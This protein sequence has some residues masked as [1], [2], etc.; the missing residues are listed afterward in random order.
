MLPWVLFRGASALFVFCL[1]QMMYNSVNQMMVRCVCVMSYQGRLS[2]PGQ[3]GSTRGSSDGAFA[4]HEGGC[5]EMRSQRLGSTV[6]A[7]STWGVLVV[8]LLQ[9]LR[10]TVGTAAA[11]AELQAS[12][13]A[14]H[15]HAS[16]AASALAG[17]LGGMQPTFV[18]TEVDVLLAL[19]YPEKLSQGPS[20]LWLF[21]MQPMLCN[22]TMDSEVSGWFVER[23]VSA[24][25]SCL[26]A[27]CCCCPGLADCPGP[28]S[29]D[30]GCFHPASRRRAAGLLEPEA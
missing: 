28:A 15:P 21:F 23:A 1:P 30:P 10:P 4:P 8:L 22:F 12:V 14:A 16:H 17:V 9:G 11:A 13:A 18:R 24:V 3:G 5:G 7:V 2:S 19:V 27:C 20:Y 29:L 26:P 25:A 6:G